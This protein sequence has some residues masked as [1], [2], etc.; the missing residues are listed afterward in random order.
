MCGIAGFLDGWRGATYNARGVA[1]AMGDALRHR[2]PDDGDVW[3]DQDAGIGLAHRRLS[4]V[5]L[6]PAARSR[7]S[8]PAAATSSPSTA[9][10][11]TLPRSARGAARGG[12]QLQGP[13]R[14]RSDA[15]SL[16]AWGVA[17]TVERP[18]GMFAFALWDRTTRTLSL[19][20][21][22]L[23]IK[24]M[25]CA[26][27]ARPLLFGSQLKAFRAHAGL[28]ADDRPRC[29]RGLSAPQ[30]HRPAAHHLSRGRETAAGAHP[31]GAPRARRRS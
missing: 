13:F 2:G 24:P 29:G 5:D 4:I 3:F 30:L 26:A 14:Y 16:R 10:S 21:D 9:R 25:Y 1:Q 11:T 28:A 6:S 20:R 23:G 8:P 22:R 27:A 17:A 19:A 15:R 12:M 7:W 31:D 18:I